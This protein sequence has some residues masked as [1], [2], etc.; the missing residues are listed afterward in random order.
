MDSRFNSLNVSEFLEIQDLLS[1]INYFNYYVEN[2]KIK[3][4]LKEDIIHTL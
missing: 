1:N 4:A 2:G 3:Y